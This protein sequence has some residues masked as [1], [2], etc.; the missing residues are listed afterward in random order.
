MLSKEEQSG[1]LQRESLHAREPTRPSSHSPHFL[2][3]LEEESSL[4]LREVS[5]SFEKVH[6]GDQ[7]E[8]PLQ[9]VHDH[10]CGAEYQQHG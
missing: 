3:Q 5:G 4:A 9:T 7:Q 8:S 6:T 2:T 1:S 10:L